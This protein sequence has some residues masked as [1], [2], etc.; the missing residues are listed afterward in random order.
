MAE[1]ADCRCCGN[2]YNV[3]ADGTI[4]Y[5]LAADPEC[6]ESPDS[7]KCRGVGQRPKETRCDNCGHE[8]HGLADSL[9]DGGSLLDLKDCTGEAW[10]GTACACARE[11]REMDTGSTEVAGYVCRV[12]AGP[13][14]CGRPVHLTANNRARSHL[15]PQGEPCGGGSDWPIEVDVKGNRRDTK[16]GGAPPA[17]APAAPVTDLELP[18]DRGGDDVFDPVHVYDDGAGGKWEH[19]GTV[20]DC[21]EPECCTHPHGFDYVD[22]DNGH[23]GD[24]CRVCGTEWSYAQELGAPGGWKCPPDLLAQMPVDVQALAATNPECWECGHEVTPLAD[25][26]EPDGS[27]TQ[28]SWT[29]SAAGVGRRCPDT[30]G[31]TPTCRP[32]APWEDRL[33]NLPRGAF[34]RRHTARGALGALVFRMETEQGASIMQA[35]VVSAG[36]HHGRTGEL[37]DL[38][39]EI[40]WTD[41][42]GQRRPRPTRSPQEATTQPTG[43]GRRSG[44]RSTVSAQPSPATS[45]GSSRKGTASG[46]TATAAGSTW[47]APMT[48]AFSTPKETVKDSDKYDRYG[49]YKLLHPSN[50][51]K[52]VQWTRATT[53]AKS[54]QDTFALSQWAQRMTL[55]G[56]T[57]RPDIVA[58]AGTLEVKADRERMNDLVEDAKKAAGDKVAA[59]LGTAVHSYTEHRDKGQDVDIPE[60]HQPTVDAYSTVLE[61]FGLEPVPGLI[62]FTTAVMQFEIAGTSDRCYRVTRDITIDLNGRPVTLYA[63]EYV[64]G[65]VKTG[66]DL[67]YGWQEIAIQLAIY[68]QGLNSSGVWSWETRTWSRPEDPTQ[69]GVQIQ[70]R[71]DV[72][73]VPHLPV[74]RSTTGAPLA[75][76]YAVDLQAG[77]AACVLCGQVRDWRKESKLATPLKVADLVQAPV[78]AGKQGRPAAPAAVSGPPATAPK[79]EVT[80]REPTLEERARAVR[81]KG[82]ASTVFQAATKAKISRAELDRLIDIMQRKLAEHVEK[83]A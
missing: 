51:R 56:A 43:T 53:F 46:R 31:V 24:F 45:A 1:R 62:E 34:F 30:C 8:G 33:G 36:A 82:E 59:N 5:H 32:Q 16:P 6:H 44:P 80:G 2:E 76:L 38:S 14:G 20:E 79:A 58:A 54:I 41:A 57:L 81:N 63:G 48:D 75:T 77:W 64:I 65:D 61:E 52:K 78:Q 47:S 25:R 21:T 27:V 22:D 55:K 23:C 72:G 67:S 19:P 73:V 83:G 69:P 9:A 42:Q 71:T 29:C 10:P 4:R 13:T 26:F 49:R 66:A 17:P 12:P 74:D 28:V 70:V 15:N 50:P 68:A 18:H 7:R 37:T 60:E 35:T 39:E 11:I 40:T 3:N